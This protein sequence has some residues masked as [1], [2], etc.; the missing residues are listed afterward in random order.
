MMQL[1]VDSYDAKMWM[2]HEEGEPFAW[3]KNMANAKMIQGVKDMRRLLAEW[4]A[5]AHTLAEAGLIARP[6]AMMKKTAQLLCD[7]SI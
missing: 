3:T 7:T 4:Q 2:I 5:V 6:E 1:G